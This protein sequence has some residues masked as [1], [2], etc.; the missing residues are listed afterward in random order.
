MGLDQYAYSVK[1]RKIISVKVNATQVVLE[2]IPSSEKKIHQWRKHP[3]M[4][5]WMEALWR[6][7][8]GKDDFNC[9]KVELNLYDL[10]RLENDINAKALPDTSGFFFGESDGSE[11]Q[12]DLEFVKKAREELKAGNVVYY[13]S[14]W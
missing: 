9:E 8:G 2:E 3:D 10:D 5:G 11:K 4:Q 13:S 7:K 12:G 1:P 14:W 6:E